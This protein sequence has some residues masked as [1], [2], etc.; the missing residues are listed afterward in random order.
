MNR[1]L[2]ELFQES[3][4]EPVN[5]DGQTY[6]P[7]HRILLPHGECKFILLLERSKSV[8]AQ[9]VDLSA[10]EGLLLVNGVKNSE[11]VIWNDTAPRTVPISINMRRPGQLVVW[12]VWRVRSITQAWVGNAGMQVEDDGECIRFHCSNGGGDIDVSN[13]EFSLRRT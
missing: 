8:V 5:V 2:A 1:T 4:G 3:N 11:L 13:F 12:N 6:T 9:G 10:K 7:A